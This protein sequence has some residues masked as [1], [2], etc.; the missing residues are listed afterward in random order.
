MIKIRIKEEFLN[1][2]LIET[3]NNALQL[4]IPISP[5]IDKKIYI[6]KGITNRVGFCD[7]RDINKYKIHITD[8]LLYANKNCIKDVIAHEILHT[9]PFSRNHFYFWT[10]YAQIMNETYGYNIKEK[11]Q[12]WFELGVKI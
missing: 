10:K 7:C 2:I 5:F 6:D 4:H 3:I 12:N 11:Y 1:E 9:C 8:K